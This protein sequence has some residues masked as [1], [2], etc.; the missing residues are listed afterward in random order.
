MSK[1]TEYQGPLAGLNV[2]DFGHYYAG[3]MVGMHL[4]DQG[5][6]VIRIVKPGESEL[7]VQQCR[8]FNR[9]KKLLTLDL[10]N[11]D[12]F[13]QALTLI[14]Q[15]DVLI[16]NF[17][18]GVMKRLGLDYGSLK[19]K[20]PGLIYLSLPG[21]ASTDKERAHI[22]AWEGI[23]SAACGVYNSYSMIREFLNYPPLYTSI[24]HCSAYGANHGAVAVMAALLAREEHGF[25]TVLEV[26]L[27][28]AGL[29]GFT[30]Y[31][32][33]NSF[34]D[35]GF[36]KL[37]NTDNPFV[38]SPDD[39]QEIQ[40]QKIGKAWRNILPPSHKW[41]LTADGRKLEFWGT[42][43]PP[44]TKR[45]YKTLGIFKQLQREGFVNESPWVW[46]LDNNLNTEFLLSPERAKRL[47]LL[48]ENAVQSKAA[49]EWETLFDNKTITNLVRSREEWL[50]L[51][52][53][54]ASGVTVQLK[55][56]QSVLTMPGRLGDI[57]G[58]DGALIEGYKEAEPVT[59]AQA[60][61][62]FNYRIVTKQP[63]KNHPASIKKGDLLKGLKV[64]DLAN[65]MA[66][67]MSGYILAQYGADVITSAAL[68]GVFPVNIKSVLEANMGKRSILNDVT[69]APGRE[70]LHRMIKRADVVIHN[71]IDGTAD[72]L[73]VRHEQLTAI[74]P[75]VTSCQVSA[76]GGTYRNRGGWEKRPGVDMGVQAETGLEAHYCGMEWPQYVGNAAVVDAV[77]ASAAAF[78]TLL[79]LWQK[80]RTGFSGEGR[81]SLARGNSHLQ[82]PWL[83]AED[84]RCDWGQASGQV[85][86]G[87]HWW[88]RIYACCDG[89]IYV[90]THQHQ[91]QV[92]VET[93]LDESPGQGSEEKA[94]EAALAKQDCARCLAK[95]TAVGIASYKV[96]RM[97]DICAVKR[98]VD[99]EET[100]EYATGGFEILCWEDHPGGTPVSFPAPS[101]VRVGENHSYL[102]RKPAP[103]RG[104]HTR[105]I[106]RELGYSEQE[107]QTLI[108]LKVSHEFQPELGNKEA[109][110]FIP[111]N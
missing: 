73:G 71:V 105:E 60:M 57:S 91:A 59:F 68:D 65:V 74:N 63:E 110:Y 24:A 37:D 14:E 26:P 84:G 45:F 38:Y 104:Q 53:N 1:I 50:S 88:Q 25:G 33:T 77:S 9:N 64:L 87:E 75:D 82:L 66:T 61:Q 8:L 5:A 40:E 58:P 100:D 21:F 107:I 44:H 36:E 23:L 28:E 2:I 46:D 3:P 83:I 111:G 85:A 49:T 47:E 55:N 108:D 13:T 81:T 106:L 16:E 48:I 98:T 34:P 19:E 69:T 32:V 109:Y 22:Q 6:S 78:T 39:S 90:G 79:G 12:D 101:W 17:R 30:Q 76:W 93:L 41:Y 72:R 10:K 11:P 103:R 18:P 52:P 86:V 92:L 27:I 67:P 42:V 54:L 97:S 95:L 94:L 89:W 20:N 62:Y 35:A 4:A 96:L 99:N 7:P 15:A 80:R 70:I 43:F 31:F 56:G 29:S 102:R 51:E